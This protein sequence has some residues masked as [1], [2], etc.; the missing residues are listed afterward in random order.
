MT[1]TDTFTPR[2]NSWLSTLKGKD[3]EDQI[4][5]DKKS[6]TEVFTMIKNMVHA[7]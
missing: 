2:T 7:Y 6:L 5:S 4:R 3:N 1:R